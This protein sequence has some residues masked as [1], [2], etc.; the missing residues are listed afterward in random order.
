MLTLMPADL[1]FVRGRSLIDRAIE[2]VTHSL[3]S[4]VALVVDAEHLVEAQG[5]ERVEIVGADKYS[6]C[7]EVYRADIDDA[8]RSKIVANAVA[9]CGQPYGYGLIAEELVREET[10][11]QLP[12][13]AHSHPICSTLVADAIRSAGLPLC[14]GIAYPAPGDIARDGLYHAVWRY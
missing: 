5:A 9:R 13:S 8:T 4:H 12:W 14:Q 1:V 6:G 3:Y 2:E 10:G 7:A 11:V